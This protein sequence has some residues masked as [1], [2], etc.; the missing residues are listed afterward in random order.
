MAIIVRVRG[1]SPRMST[2]IAIISEVTRYNYFISYL[3]IPVQL[4]K[5]TNQNSEFH[6]YKYLIL[7]L[8]SRHFLFYNR[9]YYPWEKSHTVIILQNDFP[10]TTD[11]FEGSHTDTLLEKDRLQNTKMFKL[12]M[13]DKGIGRRF[14]TQEYNQ[15]IEEIFQYVVCMRSFEPLCGGR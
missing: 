13:S 8:S 15:L 12:G 11:M 5:S 3:P 7:L 4:N 1:H 10:P 6:C 14:T 9:K 2:I